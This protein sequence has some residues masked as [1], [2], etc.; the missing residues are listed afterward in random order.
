MGSASG[1]RDLGGASADP[2]A[3]DSGVNERETL[4]DQGSASSGEHVTHSAAR[5][6]RMSGRIEYWL[7]VGLANDCSRSFEE[8]GYGIAGD[9]FLEPLAAIASGLRGEPFHFSGVWGQEARASRRAEAVQIPIRNGLEG[10]GI[11]NGR[12]LA[13]VEEGKDFVP[14]GPPEAR[15]NRKNVK[16]FICYFSQ[17]IDR[18]NHHLR[19]GRGGEDWVDFSRDIERNQSCAGLHS[20]LRAKPRRTCESTGSGHHGNPSAHSFV[21][22]ECPRGNERTE[23]GST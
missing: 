11:D 13:S 22:I 7:Q 19:S 23:D 6:A 3:H 15:T 16:S 14:P 10:V 12:T 21:N 1:H 17:R 8:E 9:K 20:R 18:L 5:H 2:R 4:C